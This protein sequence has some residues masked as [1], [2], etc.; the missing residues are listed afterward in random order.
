MRSHVSTIKRI[1]ADKYVLVGHA[2][3]MPVSAN[4]RIRPADPIHHDLSPF[5]LRRRLLLRLLLVPGARRRRRRKKVPGLRAS[6]LMDVLRR[7]V[8]PR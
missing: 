6:D 1:D 4:P 7:D 8:P 3:C 5:L 2:I